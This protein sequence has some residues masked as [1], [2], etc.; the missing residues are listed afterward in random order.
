MMEVNQNWSCVQME[1]ETVPPYTSLARAVSGAS[2]ASRTQNNGLMLIVF[3]GGN[4]RMLYFYYFTANSLSF[5]KS[6]CRY[7]YP[8]T[9]SGPISERLGG[10]WTKVDRT[11]TRSQPRPD[12]PRRSPYRKLSHR[13]RYNIS[14]HPRCSHASFVASN[15][16]AQS[17]RMALPFG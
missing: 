16:S 17:V 7:T 1:F 5:I 4:N 15:D 10:L 6:C 13:Y 11:L 2:R 8:T 12:Q 3:W 9:A 14:V